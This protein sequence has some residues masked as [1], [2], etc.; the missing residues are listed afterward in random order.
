MRETKRGRPRKYSYGWDNANRRIYIS[1][2]IFSKWRR[3][4]EERGL[5]SDDAVACYLL[6]LHDRV[7]GRNDES[8]YLP[9][10]SPS[11]IS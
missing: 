9:T 1:N 5:P 4:R 11:S 6:T 7:D 3:L 8:F 2:E 10:C